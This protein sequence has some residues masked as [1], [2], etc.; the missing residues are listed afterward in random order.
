MVFKALERGLGELSDSSNQ[1]TVLPS[2][3]KQY[4]ELSAIF[5]QLSNISLCFYELYRL[6]LNK[7]SI[8]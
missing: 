6:T 5:Q 4:L 2:E 8:K 1:Q 7:S 3:F